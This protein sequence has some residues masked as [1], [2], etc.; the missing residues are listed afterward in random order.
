[1]ACGASVAVDRRSDRHAPEGVVTAMDVAV[2]K[3]PGTGYQRLF[4]Q[5][6]QPG[7]EFTLRE[8]RAGWWRI[9]LRD[10]QRGWIS[11]EAAEL[12]PLLPSKLSPA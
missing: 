1:M 12:I 4:E 11:A 9:E 8:R 10:G 5:P 2:Y 7:V 3:G 6:L